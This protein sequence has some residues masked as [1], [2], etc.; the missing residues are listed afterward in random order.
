VNSGFRSWTEIS[1]SMVHRNPKQCRERWIEYVDPTLDRKK[2]TIEED[3][4][5]LR[6]QLKIGHKWKVRNYFI[7]GLNL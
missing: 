4:I 6:E 2:F 1:K 7:S 3:E 5:I